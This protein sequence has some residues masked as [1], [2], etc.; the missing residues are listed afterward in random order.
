MYRSSQGQM[1]PSSASSSFTKTFF[2]NTPNTRM[3]LTPHH[4]PPSKP[5]QN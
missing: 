5:F 2:Q 4:P 3:G 1:R